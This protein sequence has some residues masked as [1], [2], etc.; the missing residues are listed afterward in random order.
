MDKS[1]S[2]LLK[3][4]RFTQELGQKVEI[5]ENDFNLLKDGKLY[6]AFNKQKRLDEYL[7]LNS[8]ELTHPNTI[9]IGRQPR[10][11]HVIWGILAV[12][13]VSLLFTGFG[14]QPWWIFLLVLVI[15]LLITL[16]VCFRDKY[17]LMNNSDISIYSYSQNGIVKLLQLLKLR[18][19]SEKTIKYSQIQEAEVIYIKIPRISPFNFNPDTLAIFLTLND[20]KRVKL[21]LDHITFNELQAIYQILNFNNINVFDRQKVLTTLGNNENLFD[22]FHQKWAAV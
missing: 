1:H 21:N 12:V 15:G 22:H 3:G 4:I 20:G 7:N 18:K 8:K 19:K 10:I 14:Y 5:S 16:P 9:A 17:W 6:L 13:F 2:S 11:S